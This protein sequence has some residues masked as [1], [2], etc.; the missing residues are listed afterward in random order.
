MY[1][2]AVDATNVYWTSSGGEVNK[3]PIAGGIRIRLAY[4]PGEFLNIAVDAT[5]VYWTNPNVGTVKKVP[6]Q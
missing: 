5:S 1:S 4:D 3:A 2:V 6:K